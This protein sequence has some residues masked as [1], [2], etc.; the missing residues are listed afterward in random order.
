MCKEV[1]NVY[2]KRVLCVE[3]AKTHKSLPW[4]PVIPS[5]QD[6][7]HSNPCFSVPQGRIPKPKHPIYPE[8]AS[9]IYFQDGSVLSLTG[10]HREK[11]F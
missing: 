2:V 3:M 6:S 9:G 10:Q 8:T 7:T 1:L 11:K 4:T 5:P